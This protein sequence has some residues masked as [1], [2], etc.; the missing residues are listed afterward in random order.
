MWRWVVAAGLAAACAPKDLDLGPAVIAIHL[1]SDTDLAELLSFRIETWL[2]WAV[3]VRFGAPLL[4]LPIEGAEARVALDGDRLA[5]AEV[6]RG[7]YTT[8]TLG[9]APIASEGEQASV[10]ILHGGD[11]LA[12]TVRAPP[13][14]RLDALPAPHPA[15]RD[16]EL[17]LPAGWQD[18]FD[19]LLASLITDAGVVWSNHPITLEQWSAFVSEPVDDRELIVPGDALISGQRGALAV[20]FLRY[21]DPEVRFDG[22]IHEP[23]SMFL[24]G[25]AWLVPLEIL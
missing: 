5:L 25:T 20:H 1:G 24:S 23:L 6:G 2:V 10:E 12:M 11:R 14:L 17:P 13:V 18:D 16:L 9:L 4:E 21:L 15:G 7:L 8:A 3:D 22:P 19:F